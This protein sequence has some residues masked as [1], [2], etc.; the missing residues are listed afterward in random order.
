MDG[1]HSCEMNVFELFRHD[2]KVKQ[3]KHVF[4]KI[5]DF[6]LM[7]IREALEKYL[8]QGHRGVFLP[9]LHQDKKNNELAFLKLN[10]KTRYKQNTNALI[11]EKSFN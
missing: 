10:S 3:R 11:L 9:H 2:Q 6:D 1:N 8:H 5:C 4:S 7:Q